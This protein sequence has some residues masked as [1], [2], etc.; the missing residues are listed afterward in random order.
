MPDGVPYDPSIQRRPLAGAFDFMVRGWR[1]ATGWVFALI[2]LARGVVIPVVQL[3]RGESV[4][5]MDWVTLFALAG[6]LGLA[7]Y[8]HQEKEAGVTI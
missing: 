4:E 3:A 7:R 5:P 6:A 8:R 1:P 2:L